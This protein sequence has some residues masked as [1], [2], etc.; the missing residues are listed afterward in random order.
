MRPKRAITLTIRENWTGNSYL[1][2]IRLKD[3]NQN[4]VEAVNRCLFFLAQIDVH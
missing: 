2:K 3:G 4:S 1:H